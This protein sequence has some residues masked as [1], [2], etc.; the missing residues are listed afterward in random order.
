M[1]EM[2]YGNNHQECPAIQSVSHNPKSQQKEAHI[3]LYI[4]K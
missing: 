3:R 1:I 4:G 2:K